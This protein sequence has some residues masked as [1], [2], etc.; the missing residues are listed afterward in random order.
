MILINVPPPPSANRLWRNVPGM[1]RP[2]LD[3]KYAKWRH[4]AAWLVKI[5]IADHHFMLVECRF[6]LEL[7]VPISRRDTDNWTK[8]LADLAQHAG[9]VSNDGNMRRVLVIPEKRVDCLIA[10]TP[11]PDEPGVRKAAKP[12]HYTPATPRKKPLTAAGRKA[13]ATYVRLM[14]T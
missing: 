1:K 3:Q 7:H 8:A 9:L 6:D 5:Q 12:R 2:V 14:T 10:I 11:L 4:D 13:A